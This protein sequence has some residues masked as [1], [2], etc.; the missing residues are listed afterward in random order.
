[1]KPEPSRRPDGRCVTCNQ[2]IVAASRHAASDAFC[3]TACCRVY[4]E[5]PLSPAPTISR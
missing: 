1:M 5:V 3:S 2:P 4:F